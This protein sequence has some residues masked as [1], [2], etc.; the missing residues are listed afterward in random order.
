MAGNRPF[1][2]L[3]RLAN[4]VRP[5]IQSFNPTINQGV[6]TTPTPIQAQPNQLQVVAKPYTPFP[7]KL[8][9]GDR[10]AQ[11][12][13]QTTNHLAQFF[14]SDTATNKPTNTKFRTSINLSDRIDQTKLGT[15]AHLAQYFLSDVFT[16]YI[17]IKKMPPLGERPIP[18]TLTKPTKSK[19]ITEQGSTS[20]IKIKRRITQGSTNPTLAVRN[21]EARQGIIND[22]GV[23]FSSI[24]L[25]KP[26]TSLEKLEENGVFEM[27]GQLYS[28]TPTTEPTEDIQQ[29]SA[30]LPKKKQTTP[31]QGGELFTQPKSVEQ[32]QMEQGIIGT[33]TRQRSAIETEDTPTTVPQGIVQIGNSRGSLIVPTLPAAE[34]NQGY[35]VSNTFQKSSITDVK[36]LR[37]PIFQGDGITP[38]PS[39]PPSIDE[40][41]A[42]AKHG[43]AVLR[44]ATFVL[45]SLVLQVTPEIYQ[46]SE[47]PQNE[48]PG[49]ATYGS[50]GGHEIV[51]PR[52]SLIVALLNPLG[53]QTSYTKADLTTGIT[54][55]VGGGS[56]DKYENA[57][58]VGENRFYQNTQPYAQK[59]AKQ[60]AIGLLN[61][62]SADDISDQL[63]PLITDPKFADLTK[64]DVLSPNSS[65]KNLVDKD[66]QL[67]KNVEIAQALGSNDETIIVN[68]LKN[69][70]NED[71]IKD[72]KKGFNS[73][74]AYKIYEDIGSYQQIID[75]AAKPAT[76]DQIRP[77]SKII[78]KGDS[79]E[80][81]F[82]A[83]IK[84]YADSVN[85]SYQDFK[86][87]GQQDTFKVFVGSTRQI[88]LAFTAIAMPGSRDFSNS[89]L[90]A[91]NLLDK[92]NKL[93][94]ICSVG[95]RSGDYIKGPIVQVSVVGMLKQIRC[96]CTS[97]KVDLEIADLS[98]DVDTELPQSY[99]VS[100]DLTPLAMH[101]DQ[102]LTY[103]GKFYA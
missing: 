79:D 14:L 90:N 24:V 94:N 3:D 7:D 64:Q 80:V 48:I 52:S 53:G 102:L 98:W 37:G 54:Y 33:G 50:H 67:N 30:D 65:V 62:I 56:L 25:E 55:S 9:L 96:A 88:G 99:N 47:D 78:I 27:R 39:T 11:P 75:N 19:T 26:T 93:M 10:Y 2:N 15:T 31:Q 82:D 17:R 8:N 103:N 29:G 77:S 91:K 71:K 35:R 68:L 85:T 32:V 66:G 81:T 22:K 69:K 4:L 23:L 58:D 101:N 76:A 6:P 34:V 72:Y 18:E 21:V 87:I 61:Q 1:A 42:V 28:T 92:I 57:G 45:G 89:N 59:E 63:K 44:T 95:Q 12:N 60:N 49:D 40:D 13:L 100:L 46:G 36:D 73:S 41:S 83:F 86:H 51:D 5:D 70:I 16:K 84:T 74:T 38:T 20:P 43:G 97:V